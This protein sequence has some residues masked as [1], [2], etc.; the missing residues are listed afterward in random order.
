MYVVVDSDRDID[1]R[2]RDE[3]SRSVLSHFQNELLACVCE[4]LDLLS[5][6]DMLTLHRIVSQS[7]YASD[8]W[9]ISKNSQHPFSFYERCYESCTIADPLEKINPAP[10]DA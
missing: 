9:F 8:E 5:E 10:A 1:H 6:G 7:Q 3:I 2:A 4:L